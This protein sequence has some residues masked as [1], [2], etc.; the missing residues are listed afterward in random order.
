MTG[1]IFFCKKCKNYFIE[2]LGLQW[3]ITDIELFGGG[4]V[5]F[6]CQECESAARSEDK[7]NSV[8]MTGYSPND[9]YHGF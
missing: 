6:V 4:F 8:I 9:P 7:H 2:R 3:Q 5:P 1:K